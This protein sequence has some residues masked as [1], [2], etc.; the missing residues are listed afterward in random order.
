MKEKRQL[1]LESAEKLLATDGFHG[2]SMQKVANQAGV[3][4]G[5]IYRYF[6]DKE[7]LIE[8]IKLN[9]M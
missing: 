1:I 7:A 4:A 2:L 3:A 9:I 5:T 8:E 6:D